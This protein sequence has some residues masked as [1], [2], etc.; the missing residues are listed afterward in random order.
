MKKELRPLLEKLAADC[1]SVHAV[2]RSGRSVAVIG[3][4]PAGLSAAVELALYGHRVLLY[5]AAPLCGI[6]L[7]SRP[8]QESSSAA[9]DSFMPVDEAELSTM[10]A[11]LIS[12]GVEVW[13]SSPKGMAE[14]T[15]LMTSFDA[16]ICACGKAAVLPADSSGRV[17]D[18]LYA[19]GTCVKNQKVQDALQAAQSGRDTAR[20]VH[21]FL[22]K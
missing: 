15:G 13:T 9:P 20:C 21:A 11:A 12:C 14:L 6:T 10:T 16:V 3:S 22:M 8:A 19:A 7:L 2:P 1:R 17:Q 5:E 4:G 18:A